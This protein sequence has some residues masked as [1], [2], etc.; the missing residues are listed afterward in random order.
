LFAGHK[1]I[2]EGCDH[3]RGHRK[4][5]IFEEF[6]L[7]NLDRAVLQINI[8]QC[9]T[10]DLT[11]PKSRAVGK[12]HHGKEAERPQRRLWRWERQRRL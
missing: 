3:P 4:P 2:L 12:D 6:R 9:Q 11:K 10:D 5:T 7:A 1:V 8:C